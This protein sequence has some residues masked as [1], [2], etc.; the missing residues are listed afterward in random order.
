M[1]RVLFQMP[2]GLTKNLSEGT[3][4]IYRGRLHALARRGFLNRD[5]LLARQT[6]AIAAIRE[7]SSDAYQKRVFL[8]AIFW[9]THEMPLSAKK[10]FYDEFQTAKTGPPKIGA[11]PAAPSGKPGRMYTFERKKDEITAYEFKD[12]KHTKL[13]HYWYL[14]SGKLPNAF[15]PGAKLVFTGTPT[16]RD[17]K[18]GRGAGAAMISEADLNQEEREA[19]EK[20]K[21]SKYFPKPQS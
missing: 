15:G 13:G 4:K 9:I 17:G 3:Q 8:S 18:G 19:F 7:M 1:P 10:E 2:E 16:H 11:A 12:G 6:E 5:E 21:A 20:F 14:S